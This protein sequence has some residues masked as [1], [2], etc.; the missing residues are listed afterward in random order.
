[1]SIN[2]ITSG[3][4]ISPKSNIMDGGCIKHPKAPGGYWPGQNHWPPKE[5]GP[6]KMPL[7]E[8]GLKTKCRACNGSG[9]IKTGICYGFCGHCYGMGFHLNH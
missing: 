6:E 3:E 8:P 5:Y 1:M 9:S 2:Q 4:H 7:P